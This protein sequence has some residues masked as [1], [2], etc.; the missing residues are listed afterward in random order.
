LLKSDAKTCGRRF[1]KLHFSIDSPERRRK[2]L[3]RVEVKTKID[4]CIW[5]EDFFDYEGRVEK[6]KEEFINQVFLNSYLVDGA[7]ALE[8]LVVVKEYDCFSDLGSTILTRQDKILSDISGLYGD[9]LLSDFKF[10]VEGQEFPIHKNILAARSPVFLKMFTGNFQEKNGKQ[11]EV[12]DASKEAFGE[13]MRFIY[14]GEV[15]DFENHVEE[16]LALADRYEVT[17][18]Q[19]ICELKLMANLKDEN[20]ESIFQLAH[21]HQCNGELKQAAFSMLQS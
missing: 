1:T 3:I 5:I 17:D 6:V 15:L 19:K 4:I 9:L 11:R 12:L 21:Q 18:L 13:L 8:A 16:L 7:L 14:T 2:R 10:I 20:A